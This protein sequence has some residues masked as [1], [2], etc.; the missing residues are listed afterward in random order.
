[1]KLASLCAPN[2]HHPADGT[3]PWLPAVFALHVL[4]ALTACVSGFSRTGR[5][6]LN[7]FFHN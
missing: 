6:F 7:T 5:A 2:A 3:L 4:E 1:M